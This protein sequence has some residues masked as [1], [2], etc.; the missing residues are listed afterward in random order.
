MAEPQEL[1]KQVAESLRLA[2]KLEKFFPQKL[3]VDTVRILFPLSRLNLYAKDE[4]ILC[5]GDESKDLYVV[6]S[7]SVAITQTQGT[8]GAQLATLGPGA[9]F[10]EIALIR[11]GV[12]VASAIAAEE[13][14]A[15][16]IEYRDIQSLMDGN[17]ELAEHLKDLARQRSGG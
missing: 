11:D 3:G 2:L 4:Y 14:R 6:Y 16:R 1:D 10:G 5:Q 13:S 15:F 7:G 12:R 8:A 17:P 9:I